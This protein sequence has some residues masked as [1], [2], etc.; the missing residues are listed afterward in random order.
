MTGTPRAANI[1][2]TVDLPEPMFPVNPMSLPTSLRG[3]ATGE[4]LP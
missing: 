4:M 3:R 2:A 1:L